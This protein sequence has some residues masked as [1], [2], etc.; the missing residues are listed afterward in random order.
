MNNTFINEMTNLPEEIKNYYSTFKFPKFIKNILM[1]LDINKSL[2]ILNRINNNNSI[3]DKKVL[4]DY[5]ILI[6]NT[7]IPPA[8]N[9]VKNIIIS[10]N[11]DKK[12]GYYTFI[13][14]DIETPGFIT[15][16]KSCTLDD[17]FSIE[18]V[19]NSVISKPKIHYT[20][21]NDKLITDSIEYGE[22]IKIINTILLKNIT[23]FFK[24]YMY[25]NCFG[26][27]NYG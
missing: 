16:Y 11:E 8:F 18:I 1:R 7:Y 5:F 12:S 23:D 9:E 22:N 14:S 27:N 24:K 15:K 4:D 3:L 6:S 25:E 13:N 19:T 20:F 26:G 21:I 2:K 17:T 10:N